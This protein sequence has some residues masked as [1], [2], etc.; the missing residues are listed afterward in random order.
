[1]VAFPLELTLPDK[2][3]V[4]FEELNARRD[5]KDPGSTEAESWRKERRSS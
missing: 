3:R 2:V 5:G 1:M 4:R